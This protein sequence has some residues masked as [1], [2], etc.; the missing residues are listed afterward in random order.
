MFKLQMLGQY[1]ASLRSLPGNESLMFVCLC[2][3]VFV[4]V[5]LFCFCG[6]FGVF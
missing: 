2:V 5:V 4:C 1:A 3:C 6:C